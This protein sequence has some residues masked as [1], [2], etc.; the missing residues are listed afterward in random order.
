M[1]RKTKAA[2]IL[3]YFYKDGLDLPKWTTAPLHTTHRYQEQVYKF[4]T[5]RVSYLR[6]AVSL[7]STIVLCRMWI[8]GPERAFLTLVSL[9]LSE[10]RHLT[11]AQRA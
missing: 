3:I 9:P 8:L 4:L 6:I 10:I 2:I 5:Y 1:I 7:T 11:S